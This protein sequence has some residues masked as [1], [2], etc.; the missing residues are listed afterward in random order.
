M[1][2]EVRADPADLF[3]HVYAEPTRALAAQ[4]DFLLDE[5]AQDRA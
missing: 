5:I 2:G 4:R 1:S 3:S